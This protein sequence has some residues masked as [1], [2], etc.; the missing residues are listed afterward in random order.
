MKKVYRSRFIFISPHY[1][2]NPKVA[3]AIFVRCEVLCI[4]VPGIQRQRL[5][6]KFLDISLRASA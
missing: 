5:W 6:A 2:I 1:S 3:S 4:G